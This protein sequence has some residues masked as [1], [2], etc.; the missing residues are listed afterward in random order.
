MFATGSGAVF[1]APIMAGIAYVAMGIMRLVGVEIVVRLLPA[2]WIGSFVAVARIVAVVDMAIEMIV[3][4]IPGAGSYEH[5]SNEPIRPIVAV[6][7]AVIGSK[8]IVAIRA[9]WSWPDIDGY[10]RKRTGK[11]A[12]HGRSENRIRKRFQTRHLFHL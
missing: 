1:T 11:A 10:L 8:V 9:D 12:Q 3:A 4:V 7:C 6:R 2:F 5:S